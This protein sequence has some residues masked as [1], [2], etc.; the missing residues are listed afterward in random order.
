VTTNPGRPA[1]RRGGRARFLTAEEEQTIRA[2]LAAGY[3]QD[4]AAAEVGITRST[5]DARLR[6]QLADLRVGQGR[7]ERRRAPQPELTPDEI[8]WRAHLV[9]S[10]WPAERWL[11][12][13]PPDAP[14]HRPGAADAE[15]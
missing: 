15:Q 10:R 8:A 13:E 6:D 7:R 11:R 12:P 9:R 5:P 2:A 1:N 3:T 14:G 4:E